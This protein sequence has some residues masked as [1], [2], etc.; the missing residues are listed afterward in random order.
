[1]SHEYFLWLI[2]L[3]FAMHILEEHTLGWKTWATETLGF[4]KLDWADFYVTNAVFFAAACIIANL[5]WLIPFLSLGMTAG[6]MINGLFFHLIP[7][8]VKRVFSPGTFTGVIL[9]LPFGVLVY[10][11]AYLDDQLTIPVFF[12][13]IL[14]GIIFMAYP[15]ILQKMKV[16]INS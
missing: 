15:V 9:Y 10:Y 6:F 1:M 14:L 2:V 12:S 8:L 13:S 7:T 3:S 16:K 11:G 4:E 5:G